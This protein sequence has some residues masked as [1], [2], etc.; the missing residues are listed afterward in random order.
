M[1]NCPS[2]G[3]ENSEQ[4]NVCSCGVDL[5]LLQCVESL[6]ASWFNQALEAAI[7]KEYGK[8]VELLSACCIA[9]PS[10]AEAFKLRAKAW[11]GLGCGAEAKRSCDRIIE[12]DPDCHELSQLTEAISKL[13]KKTVPSKKRRTN[14]NT[15]KIKS[16]K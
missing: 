15:R 9:N 7:A 11:M 2:C 6:T 12:L 16:G 1:Y 14:K 8:A 3:K 5:T 13:E 10:D 4:K